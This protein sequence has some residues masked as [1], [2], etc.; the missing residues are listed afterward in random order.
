MLI[1]IQ[2]RSLVLRETLKE[3]KKKMEKAEKS[4]TPLNEPKESLITVIKEK[5]TIQGPIPLNPHTLHTRISQST[6][7]SYRFRSNN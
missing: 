1:Y 7:I 6:V 2:K 4:F 5:Y 3:R